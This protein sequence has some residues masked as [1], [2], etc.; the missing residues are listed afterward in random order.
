MR[1]TEW[2]LALAIVLNC[3]G[4]LPAASRFFTGSSLDL[5][6]SYLN[7][8]N[9]GGRVRARLLSNISTDANKVGDVVTARV[10]SP[11]V[12]TGAMLEGTVKLCK[13][14]GKLKGDAALM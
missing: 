5:A 4:S 6:L 7:E 2:I 8:T 10:L 13:K 12:L 9:N 1:K 3:S 14:G 11:E